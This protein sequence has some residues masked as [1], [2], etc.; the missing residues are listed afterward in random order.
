M[1]DEDYRPCSYPQL[2]AGAG[3]FN[4]QFLCMSKDV[5]LPAKWL[6]VRERLIAPG[7]HSCIGA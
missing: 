7:K 2:G 6:L 4:Q 5:A 1:G 3:Q